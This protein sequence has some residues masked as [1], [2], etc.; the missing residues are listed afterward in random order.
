MFLR[1]VWQGCGNRDF[2]QLSKDKLGFIF[3]LSEV[4][5]SLSNTEGVNQ[6]Y[7][8]VYCITFSLSTTKSSSIIMKPVKNSSVLCQ[9]SLSGKYS[10]SC[11][12]RELNIMIMYFSEIHLSTDKSRCKIYLSTKNP[13][14]GIGILHPLVGEYGF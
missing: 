9:R 6:Y 11:H 5:V 14:S 2:S 4:D 1:M 10:I 13:K 8:G 12:R 3:Y 7:T